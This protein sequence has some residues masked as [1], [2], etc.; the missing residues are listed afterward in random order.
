M[1]DALGPSQRPIA[2]EFSGWR[3]SKP[4]F[5]GDDVSATMCPI[6]VT[7]CFLCAIVCH[8]GHLTHSDA[9]GSGACES[10]TS[11]GRS[12]LNWQRTHILIAFS[13][14]YRVTRDVARG[15]APAGR[16]GNRRG[17]QLR[18]RWLESSQLLTCAACGGTYFDRQE[19]SEGIQMR[20]PWAQPVYS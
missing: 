16:G 19:V 15:Q 18:L 14:C 7:G 4:T 8:F 9:S 10:D 11:G 2:I 3:H 5:V 1:W 6:C 13:L 20:L 17:W 12:G